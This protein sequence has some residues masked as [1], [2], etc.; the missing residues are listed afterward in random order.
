MKSK[1]Y[2]IKNSMREI[3]KL[4]AT[5]FVVS[6]IT[7]VLLELSP[8]DPVQSY[9]NSE[10]ITVS[11]EQQQD[12]A[13]K[14][15][16]N[17][18]AVERFITWLTSILQG[19]FGLSM[20]YR[21][22]VL[23]V[24]FERFKESMLLIFGS[25]FISGISGFSLG[26]FSAVKKGTWLDKL[27]RGYSIFIETIPTF[28]LGLLFVLFFSIQLGWFPFGMSIPPGK[29][30]TEVTILDRIR[31]LILPMLTLSFIGTADITMYTRQEVLKIL[32]SDYIL[33]AKTRG[34]SEWQII[35]RH[36]LKNASLPV[37]TIQLTSLGQLF[38][39]TILIENVFSYPGLGEMTLQAGLRQDVPLILGI[40]IF[41]TF[42]FVVGNSMSKV[43]Y[44][45][46]DPRLR[47]GYSINERNPN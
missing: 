41:T 27:I 12:I 35:K 25:W 2:L 24:I 37:L 36:I 18:P 43:F 7:F 30:L 32:N 23:S 4:L 3:I 11:L 9:I 40:V 15:G 29:L 42:I 6:L 13:E 46:L 33:L 28:W 19:D 21:Q 17:E 38:S 14:W 8:L 39:R 10:G 26:I 44:G 1:K 47:E 45:I 31:H 22:P 16:M 34:D 5:L 20:I